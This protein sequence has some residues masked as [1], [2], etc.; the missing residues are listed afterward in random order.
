MAARE[1]LSTFYKFD[2]ANAFDLWYSNKNAQKILVLYFG[3]HRGHAPIWLAIDA[4]GTTIAD[5]KR[6][7]ANAFREMRHAAR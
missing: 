3:S 2:E 7:P 6:L 4:S 5:E 1:A